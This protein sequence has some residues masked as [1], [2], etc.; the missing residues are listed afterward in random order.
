MTPDLAAF[1]DKLYAEGQE[2]D[3]EQPDRLDRRRNLESESA[4]LLRSLIY[5]ISP[6]S[7]LELG[8]SNG[9]S[10]IWMADVVNLTT[11]D[12]DPERSLDAA[13]NLRAAGVE[14]KFNESSPM[15]QPYLP[16]PPMNNGISFSL[17][18]NNHSM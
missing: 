8:T 12:N 17:M 16:I 13:A 15:E 9:Y 7:V 3:A 5:G 14:E 2:F 6:K 1:L 18:P 11:V 4:A 10:T